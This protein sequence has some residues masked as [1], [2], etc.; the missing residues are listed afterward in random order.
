M[1]VSDGKGCRLFELAFAGLIT[2]EVVYYY[3]EPR[4]L[5]VRDRLGTVKGA[6]LAPSALKFAGDLRLADPRD[7]DEHLQNTMFGE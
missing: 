3:F 2:P 5:E 6:A 7:I 4:I 1:T